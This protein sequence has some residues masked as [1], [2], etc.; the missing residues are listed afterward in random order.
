MAERLNIEAFF[1]EIVPD[2]WQYAYA[3]RESGFPSSI[4]IFV[5]GEHFERES[6]RYGLLNF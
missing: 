2:L 4:I 3:F 6:F 1:R 5:N